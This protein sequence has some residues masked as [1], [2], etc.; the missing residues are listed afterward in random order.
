MPKLKGRPL[1]SRINDAFL[2][3]V[4]EIG[5]QFKLDT[6]AA[7]SVIGS[8]GTNSAQVKPPEKILRGSGG[9]QLNT[10]EFTEKTLTYEGKSAREKPY[11]V[12]GL[13]ISLLCGSACNELELITK[14]GEVRRKSKV[15][16]KPDFPKEF[17]QLFSGWGC[18]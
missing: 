17:P 13:T 12:K 9:I 18:L 14:I 11:V 3:P 15:K 4:Y 1:K 10:L 7:S 16:D 5:V 2:G 6:G 8:H